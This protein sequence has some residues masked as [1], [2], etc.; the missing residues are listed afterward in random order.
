[1]AK[2][3]ELVGNIIENN[4]ACKAL[5]L[6]AENSENI[7]I[8]FL[9]EFEY[10]RSV[11]YTSIKSKEFKN[12]YHKSVLGVGYYGVGEYKSRING[13]K[14]KEYNAWKSIMSRC[15]DY[16][17]TQLNQPTYKNVTVCEE[18]H[19]YQ[20]FA[21]WYDENYPK[22]IKNIRFDIDKDLLQENINNKIYSPK[23]CIFLPKKVNI[24]ISKKYTNENIGIQIINKKYR[25]ILLDYETE[26]YVN[27]GTYKTLKDAQK[28]CIELKI[29]NLNY[30]KEYL[31]NLNY[32]SNDIINLIK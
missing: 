17:V 13:L 20:N 27:F 19:N 28:A 14:T 26:K 16:N 24:F 10:E 23:T 9:D 5:V 18:W 12:P 15:Y 11:G 3:K 25:A 7:I 1:M 6:R 30:I 32:L 29:K 8:K 22:H 31:R 4:E 2:Y 21:K